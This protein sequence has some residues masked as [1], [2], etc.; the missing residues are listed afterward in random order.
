[1]IPL[2]FG[3]ERRGLQNHEGAWEWWAIIAVPSSCPVGWIRARRSPG[4]YGVAVKS[5]GPA[6]RGGSGE[7][8]L[9]IHGATSSWKCWRGVI[10]L[11][12]DSFDVLAPNLAGHAGLPRP[13]QPHTISDLADQLESDMDAAGFETAHLVGNSLGG[14]LAVELAKRGRGRSVVAFSPAGGWHPG[15]ERVIKRFYSMRRMARAAQVVPP[16]ALSGRWVRQRALRMAC[17]H[18]DRL[19]PRQA[20]AAARSALQCD[21]ADFVGLEAGIEP[22]RYLEVTSPT[23]IAWSQHDR[24][25]PADHYAERWRQELP[26]AKWET[27]PEVG[28]VPMYDDPKLVSQTITSWIVSGSS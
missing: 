9:L 5:D 11:V 16:S 6:F 17:E 22:G 3:A 19:T 18:G 14:W 20:L 27:L 8:L 26:A 24:T 10:P 1:M 7:P 25:I 21:L 4:R 15:E 28:H 12:T 2:P 13:K 23:L